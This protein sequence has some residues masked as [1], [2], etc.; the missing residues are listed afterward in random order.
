MM[1]N[2]YIVN[3][4]TVRID[5][6]LLGLNL[7][8]H[9][10]LVLGQGHTV[11][12]VRKVSGHILVDWVNRLHFLSRLAK[13]YHVWWDYLRLKRLVRWKRSLPYWLA[14]VRL[15]KCVLIFRVVTQPRVIPGTRV[16]SFLDGIFC[17]W[18]NTIMPF[19]AHEVLLSL[20]PV[21]E[22]RILAGD[23]WILGPH[24]ASVSEISFVSIVFLRVC[25]TSQH[26]WFF[27]KANFK[28]YK[29]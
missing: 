22:H 7:V 6:L 4:P 16:I 24:I 14:S 2:L 1:S 12:M 17:V 20:K 3:L 13:A 29:I 27:A 10:S 15:T 23:F 5:S 8:A 19:F 25:A 26:N 28:I 11:V 9:L 18:N 21:V